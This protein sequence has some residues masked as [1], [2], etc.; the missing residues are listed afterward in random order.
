MPSN[1][2]YYS[3]CNYDYGLKYEKLESILKRHNFIKLSADR[4]VHVSFGSSEKVP[5]QN[6]KKTYHDP[7]F[8]TQHAGIKNTLGGQRQ[9][10]EKS[11][12]FKTIK[13]L[14]PNGEKYLPK[15]KLCHP[16]TVLINYNNSSTSDY[17]K[18]VENFSQLYYEWLC[19]CVIFPHFGLLNHNQHV[20][21]IA[22]K[23]IHSNKKL[24]SEIISELVLQFNEKR[25]MVDIYLSSK[26]IG[27]IQFNKCK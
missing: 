18:Y 23:M 24:Q 10:I 21:P 14:I 9:I 3:I 4:P 8:I 12:L 22:I 19:H 27:I 25:D 17:N 15:I 20:S 5:I 13:Q 11:M 1:A 7:L 26:K 6:G 16:N 2:M